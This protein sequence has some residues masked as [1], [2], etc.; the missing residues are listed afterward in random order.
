MRINHDKYSQSHTKEVTARPAYDRPQSSIARRA[1]RCSTTPPHLE[2]TQRKTQK[3]PL[4]QALKI[5]PALPLAQP[6]RTTNGRVLQCL[7]ADSFNDYQSDGKALANT[8]KPV[9]QSFEKALDEPVYRSLTGLIS[10]WNWLSLGK[11]NFP[12][13]HKHIGYNHQVICAHPMVNS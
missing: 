8:L 12:G 2:K 1:M 7:S 13:K 4:I 6:N 11:I 10:T 9:I 5:T 3:L